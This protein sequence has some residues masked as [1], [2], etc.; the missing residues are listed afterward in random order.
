[1]KIV[2]SNNSPLGYWSM[3]PIA[4]EAYRLFLAGDCSH[5]EMLT[6]H[7]LGWSA[8]D[9]SRAYIYIV[10]AVVPDP[11]PRARVM[12]DWLK[13]IADLLQGIT[14]KGFCGYPSREAGYKLFEK[15]GFTKSELRIDDEPIFFL[16]ND[17]ISQLAVAV[18]RELESKQSRIPLWNMEDK[19]KFYQT[20]KVRKY[21]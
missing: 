11:G 10:G 21:R 17:G 1:M 18:E 6:K 15:F 5:E 12:L 7:C 14:I 16:D 4:E 2:Y 9:H 19:R 20:L 3:I 8:I 13:L